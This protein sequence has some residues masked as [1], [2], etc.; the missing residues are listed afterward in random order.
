MTNKDKQRISVKST[1]NSMFYPNRVHEIEQKYF[2]SE[3][4]AL[5]RPIRADRLEMKN[6]INRS[7]FFFA[8]IYFENKLKTMLNFV[9]CFSIRIASLLLSLRSHRSI[10]SLLNF[11]ID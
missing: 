10:R 9:R 2:Q 8:E 5:L 6:E 4:H 1:N 7:T 11:V 3:R